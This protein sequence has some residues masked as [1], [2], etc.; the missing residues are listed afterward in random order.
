MFI[1][2]DSPPGSRAD[3]TV[4]PRNGGARAGETAPGAWPEDRPL[5]HPITPV[6]PIF[7][8]KR[9]RFRPFDSKLS[10]MLDNAQ[11]NLEATDDPDVVRIYRNL[12][13]ELERIAL[14]PV[15]S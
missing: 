14:G 1:A 2:A 4:P 6:D 5:K 10:L 9:K 3:S 11:A 7:H 15:K 13:D 12:V 8:P